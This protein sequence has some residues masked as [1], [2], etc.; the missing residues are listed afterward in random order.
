MTRPIIIVEVVSL[1]RLSHGGARCPLSS[2][3]RNALTPDRDR[4]SGA[5]ASG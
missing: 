1:G 2:T 4:L 5:R 3:W